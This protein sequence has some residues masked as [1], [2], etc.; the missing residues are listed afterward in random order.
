MAWTRL[1]ELGWKPDVIERQLAHAERSKVRA[2]Y[3]RA[4]YLA[5]RR[6][7]MQ[8]WA[9]YLDRLRERPNRVV[10]LDQKVSPSRGYNS[11]KYGPSPARRTRR[12][13]VQASA[14]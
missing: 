7:M 2:A 3:N 6:E 10:K 1:N 12:N 5:E 13:S 14:S 11:A 9:D 4:S 8:V